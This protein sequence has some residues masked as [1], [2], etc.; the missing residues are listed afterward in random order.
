MATASYAQFIAA[1]KNLS[2]S[3]V[4]KTH[5]QP[6]AVFNRADLPCKFCWFPQ[7]DNAPL[8]FGGDAHEFRRRE[9]DLIVVYESTAKKADPTFTETVALMDA[10]ETA[11]GNLDAGQSNPSWQIRSQLYSETDDR[12][13]WAVIATIQGT[14]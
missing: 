2:V 5:D 1:V 9:V 14:G 8:S 10:L 6:P 13:Y 4:S 12:R 7:G 11:L 3:G